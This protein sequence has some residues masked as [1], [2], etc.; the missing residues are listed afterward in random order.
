MKKTFFTLILSISSIFSF[1]QVVETESDLKKKVVVE[2]EGWITKGAFT[3][4]LAQTSLTNWAAGGQN[5][6]AVNGMANFSANYTK[7]NSSWVNNLDLG[8]GII[9]QGKSDAATIQKSDDKVDFASKYGRKINDKL[10]YAALL[11]FKTQMSAGYNYPNDSVEISNLFAPAYLV[12][13]LG[14][15]YK[16]NDKFSAFIAPVTSKLTFVNNQTLADVGAFGVE[17]GKNLKSEFGGYVKIAYQD[18]IMEN[19]RL[20]T[21]IDFFSNYT[22]KPQNIDINW[23][24][25]ITMKINKY[26]SASINTQLI[27]DDNIKISVDSDNDGITDAFGPRVQFKELLGIGF[28]YKF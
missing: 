27:Y 20:A 13:A 7:G 17:P 18:D 3:L 24:L 10:Y 5:S 26:L 1:A 15:D 12:S 14:I 16:P 6:F 8:Y 4:N 25:L 19:V 9:R 21:K 11:N 23:E 22:E 28:S 2:E